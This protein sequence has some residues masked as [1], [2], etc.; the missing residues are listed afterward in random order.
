MN[1][2]THCK[3]NGVNPFQTLINSIGNEDVTCIEFTDK[4]VIGDDYIFSRI[5]DDGCSTQQPEKKEAYSL[6]IVA[7]VAGGILIVL[8]V[9]IIFFIVLSIRKKRYLRVIR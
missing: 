2:D 8:V 9:V 6:L 5:S 3:Y 7:Y 4:G 1:R